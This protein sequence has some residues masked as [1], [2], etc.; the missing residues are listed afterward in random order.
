MK[1]KKL[2]IGTILGAGLVATGIIYAA[3]HIDSP[4]VTSQTTDITDVYVFRGSDPNNLVFVANTQGLL[5]PAASATAQFDA[6]TLIEFNIDTN[7]D[8][9]EDLLLQGVYDASA[10]KMNVYGPV[11]PSET[12]KRS[13]L[14]GNVTASVAVTAYGAASPS[15]G[16]STSGIKVFA[17]PRD[18]P[19]FFDLNRYKMIIAGTATSFNNPGTDAFAGTNVLSLVIEVP[20]T[21]LGT[22]TGNKVNVWVETKKKI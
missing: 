17:G 16:T 5:T 19:F 7:G 21:L 6:N 11:A 2:L 9:V 3:D 8:A 22:V 15:I 12:G 13:K 1:R 4:A 20:K 10:G 18:D 14:E